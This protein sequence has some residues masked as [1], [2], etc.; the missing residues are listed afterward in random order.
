MVIA[1]MILTAALVVI[2]L[3]AVRVTGPDYGP[4][5]AELPQAQK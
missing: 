5:F 2:G 4:V 1:A 3:T